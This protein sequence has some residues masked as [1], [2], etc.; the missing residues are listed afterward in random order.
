VDALVELTSRLVAID[1]INP[2]LVPGASGEGDV[3]RLVATWL[4]EAGLEVEVTEPAPGRP[5]VVGRARGTGG[6]RTLLLNAHLD[7]VGVA[8][9]ALP[10][11]ADVRDGRQHGLSLIHNSE[12]TRHTLI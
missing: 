9:V 6:G 8:G 11:E 5:N 12:H 7:T 3:G 2:G 10:F 1:S 4:E